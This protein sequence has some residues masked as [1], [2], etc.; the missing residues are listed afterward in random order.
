M[1]QIQGRETPSLEV[2]RLNS[3]R[4]SYIIL[5]FFL[6]FLFHFLELLFSLVAKCGLASM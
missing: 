6:T 5:G 4:R 1:A 3:T 2:A